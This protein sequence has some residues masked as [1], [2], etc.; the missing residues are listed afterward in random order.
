MIEHKIGET[1]IFTDEHS[2]HHKLFTK[3]IHSGN[4]CVCCYFY[5]NNINCHEHR[6]KIGH[7]HA[8]LRQD[9]R[10]VI[11]EKVKA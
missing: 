7:C 9:F 1:F 2:R 5:E 4:S 10:Y 11:F 6:Y 8:F 3:E